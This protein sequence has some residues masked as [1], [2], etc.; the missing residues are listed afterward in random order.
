M[1][2]VVHTAFYQEQSVEDFIKEEFKG[3]CDF[4]KPL[5]HK[6]VNKLT[7]LKGLKVNKTIEYQWENF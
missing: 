7:S 4:N 5:N 3:M 6:E 1:I 2:A